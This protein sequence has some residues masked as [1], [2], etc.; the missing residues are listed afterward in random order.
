MQPIKIRC[1]RQLTMKM[2][3]STM[4][5]TI[6]S[7]LL[8]LCTLVASARAA[9]QNPPAE[10]LSTAAQVR[11]LTPGQ[12]AQKL[13]VKLTGVITFCDEGLNSRFVQDNTAGIYF[14]GLNANMPALTAGQVVE[15]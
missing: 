13:P 15:I 11:S 4:P 9:G 7:C 1:Q 6:K 10:E 12:A 8:V 14:R 2:I 5:D 3:S